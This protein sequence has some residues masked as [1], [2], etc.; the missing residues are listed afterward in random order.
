MKNKGF[1]MPTDSIIAKEGELMKIGKR[2]NTM[3]ARYYVL[4]D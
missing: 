3:R 2:T 1:I 4:R